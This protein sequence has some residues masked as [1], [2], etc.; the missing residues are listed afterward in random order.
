MLSL[1]KSIDQISNPKGKIKEVKVL[2]RRRQTTTEEQE[3]LDAHNEARFN[4]V[5]KAANMKKIVSQLQLFHCSLCYC[6]RLKVQRKYITLAILT[7]GPIC[8]Q[9]NYFFNSK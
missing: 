9:E 4:V 5:P 6:Y 7:C 1:K 8:Y 2:R 3:F